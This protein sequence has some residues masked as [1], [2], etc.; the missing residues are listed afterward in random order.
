MSEPR[1]AWVTPQDAAKYLSLNVATIYALV[2]AGKLKASRVTG[3]RNLRFKMEWLEQW[4]LRNTE[5]SPT[6]TAVNQ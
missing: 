2:K 4:M 6:P 5:Y 3:S 1:E